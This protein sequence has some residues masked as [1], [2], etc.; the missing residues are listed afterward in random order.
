AADTLPSDAGGLDPARAQAA[1]ESPSVSS[2]G[3]AQ[4]DS[5]AHAGQSATGA[6]VDGSGATGAAVDGSGAT[7][8]GATDV[9]ATGVGAATGGEDDAGTT[10]GEAEL[11]IDDGAGDDGSGRPRALP[12]NG[13]KKQE[14]RRAEDDMDAKALR[15]ASRKAISQRRYADAYRLAGKAQRKQPGEPAAALRV[16]SA[17]GMK[18][19]GAAKTA[20]QSIKTLKRRRE[21]RSRCRDLGTRLGL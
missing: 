19:K 2:G 4:T 1:G 3:A 13:S 5:G 21:L 18:N 8:V 9:G 6:A 16:E 20:L 14:D 7:D 12:A 15:E 11:V 17:C 10:A